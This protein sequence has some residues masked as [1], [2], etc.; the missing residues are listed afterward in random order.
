MPAGI[1][2]GTFATPDNGE[3]GADPRENN[4]QN[5]TKTGGASQPHPYRRKQYA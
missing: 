5:I 3:T 4:A 1:L 2:R